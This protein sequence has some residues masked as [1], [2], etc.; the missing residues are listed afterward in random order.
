MLKTCGYK[1][2]P[3]PDN[4]ATE[5]GLIKDAIW[6]ASNA[7]NIDPRFILAVMLQESEGCVRVP[8]TGGANPNPGLMQSHAGNFSCNPDG[9]PI[10]P[11]PQDQIFGMI[12]DGA[13][14][15]D[16]GDGL[17]ACLN[18]AINPTDPLAQI[19]AP[20]S[21]TQL[22]YMAARL[23]NSGSFGS[24]VGLGA[25][26][27]TRCYCSDIANRLTGW[28]NADTINYPST[29]CFD[30]TLARCSSPAS[31]TVL[32]DLC[33]QSRL[34]QALTRRHHTRRLP[35]LTYGIEPG[36]QARHWA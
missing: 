21:E 20:V 35:R 18:E 29:C 10:S 31:S 3:V 19:P 22:Y 4:S 14:G 7:T 27:A 9:N 32:L 17:A 1:K 11:C 5:I 8:T 23:Y 26:G 34:R 36:A 13:A 15:T 6:N 28:T 30:T 12:S 25:P 24:Y 16:A 33:L 2:P